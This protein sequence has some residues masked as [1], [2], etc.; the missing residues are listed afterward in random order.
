MAV[1]VPMLDGKKWR[2]DIV[3]FVSIKCATFRIDTFICSGSERVT[4]TE[5]TYGLPASP[6][7]TPAPASKKST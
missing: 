2:E 1:R 7:R 3:C 6:S 4:V 5:L